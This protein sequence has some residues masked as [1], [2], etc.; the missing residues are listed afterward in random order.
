[1]VHVLTLHKLSSTQSGSFFAAGGS[2]MSIGCCSLT[3][4][5]CCQFK[6]E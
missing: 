4:N 5:A 2:G 1:M 3:S 6:P